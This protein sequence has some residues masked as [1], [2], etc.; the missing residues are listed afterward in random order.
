MVHQNPEKESER[1][2]SKSLGSFFGSKTTRHVRRLWT[3]RQILFVAASIPATSQDTAKGQQHYPADDPLTRRIW[4]T[5]FFI[6][7]ILRET[8]NPLAHSPAQTN[9]MSVT[10]NTSPHVRQHSKSMPSTPSQR[11]R[12]QSEQLRSPSVSR[13]LNNTSPHSDSSQTPPAS[14][15][16]IGGCKYETGMARA[17][18]RVPYAEGPDRLDP[19]PA[20]AKKELGK[21][22]EEK[23]SKKIQDLYHRLLPTPES[24][25][26][27]QRLVEKLEKILRGRWPKSAIKVNVFGSTGN[28]L[29]TSDSDVDICITTD[30]KEMSRVCSIAEL[31]AKHGMERIV[32]VSSAKVPIVKV[33]D[34]ELQVACDLNVNNPI[35]LENTALI[36]QYVSLDPRVR[37]LAMIIKYWAK[38]RILNDAGMLPILPRV[39]HD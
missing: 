14:R 5:H 21:E 31:L 39:S 15:R 35:A 16:P 12:S 3:A 20:K 6:D 7:D 34:P 17:R 10:P 33:W 36:R 23:L 29:G 22:Q 19:D 4:H 9:T 8:C 2:A 11:S 25:T 38:R 1:L 13:T 32:C 27:R 37:P 30:S 24:E 26:R 28:N 18:R